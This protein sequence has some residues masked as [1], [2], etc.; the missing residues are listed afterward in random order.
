VKRIQDALRQPCEL[1]ASRSNTDASIGIAMAHTTRQPKPDQLLKNADSPCMA[2]SPTAAAPIAS[3]K[4]RWTA[5]MK[6]RRGLEF[7]MRQAVMCGEFEL[8]YP[9]L[10][11]I[12]DKRAATRFAGCESAAA[13]ASSQARH[14]FAGDFHSDRGRDRRHQPAGRLGAANRL[15][16][17]RDL[18]DQIMVTVNVSPVQF[19]QDNLV[20]TVVDALAASGL[21]AERLEL[22]ITE[23]LLLHRQRDDVWPCC[24]QLKKARRPDRDGRF[25]HRLFVAELPAAVSVRQDQDSTALLKDVASRT[26]RSPSCRRFVSI[27]QSRNIVTTAKGVE[28]RSNWNCSRAGLYGMQGYLFS[29]PKSPLK[30][31]AAGAAARAAALSVA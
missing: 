10:V 3:S 18:A 16:R 4:P 31:Q 13:L 19:K 22:E 21:P 30:C 20:Q 27:A 28:T 11:N 23:S 6:A 15:R 17:G 9:P 29:K 12:Q 24:H 2:P 5:R 25:W 1:G 8:H 14:D 7:D 26:A